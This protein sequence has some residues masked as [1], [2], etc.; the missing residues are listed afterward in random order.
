MHALLVEDSIIFAEALRLLL[1]EGASY[2]I[3]LTHVAKLADLPSVVEPRPDVVLL[4][5]SLP[6]SEGIDSIRGVQVYLPGVPIVVLT[7]DSDEQQALQMVRG[8]AQDY[9]VKE[10]FNIDTLVRAMRYAIERVQGEQ[11][12]HQLFQADRLAA[13]GRLAA[14][15]AHEISNPATFVQA[16]WQLLDEQILRAESALKQARKALAGP[17]QDPLAVAKGVR[18]ALGALTEVRRLSEQNRAGVERICSVVQD[19]RGFSRLEPG[20]LVCIHPNQVVNDA[21]H[22]VSNVVRHKAQLVKRLGSVPPV[23]LPRGRLDQILT[24]LLVNAA[25]AIS[26]GPPQDH[27]VTVSTVELD[28]EVIIAV[29]DTGPGMTPEQQKK[30]FEPFFTTKPRGIGVGLGLSICLEIARAHGGDIQCHSEP[31]KGTRFEVSFPPLLQTEVLVSTSPLPPVT[32]IATRARVL[33]IDDEPNICEVYRMLLADE[34][35]IVTAANGRRALEL[36]RGATS[37]DVIVSDVMMPDMDAA[38]LIDAIVKLV[39]RL[40]ERL[41]LYTGGAVS[42]RARQLVEAGQIPVLYKPLLTEDLKL[43]IRQRLSLEDSHDD[44]PGPPARLRS[45]AAPEA[46]KSHTR[47]PSRASERS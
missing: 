32:D 34:F 8:G 17:T 20:E 24:N 14:G 42:E 39:P 46:G 3:T 2:E 5:L 12:K 11:L 28:D 7:A 44:H 30:V 45:S 26:G 41:I 9:L 40:S 13:V 6:D 27:T 37:F 21:C 18:E 43:A 38:E 4:D 36:V 16:S 31:G 29:E 22:L 23:A 10:R 35:E 33:L 1:V 47:D 15:V 19:L 25:Q